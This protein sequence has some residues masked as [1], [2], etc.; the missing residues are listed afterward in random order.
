MT[1]Y[2]KSVEEKGMEIQTKKLSHILDRLTGIEKIRKKQDENIS[3][4]HR[5]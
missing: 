1:V 3:L 5:L 2:G 4:Y